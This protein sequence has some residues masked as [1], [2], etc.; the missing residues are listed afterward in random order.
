MVIES[1][2]HHLTILSFIPEKNLWMKREKEVEGGREE[3]SS[4]G[5]HLHFKVWPTVY[6]SL[7][8]NH[9]KIGYRG[10]A[11]SFHRNK[12]WGALNRQLHKARL[13]FCL[14]IGYRI[15]LMEI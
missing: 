5:G 1:C 8:T 2:C 10:N 15:R 3:G 9:V 14:S 12:E 11:I 7:P 13:P 4:V 6:Q